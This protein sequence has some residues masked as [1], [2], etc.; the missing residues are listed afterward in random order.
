MIGRGSGELFSMGFSGQGFVI[1]QPSEGAPW[2][3]AAST[4]QQSGS[5]IGSLFN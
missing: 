1:I 2:G 3:L 4:Q 5:A